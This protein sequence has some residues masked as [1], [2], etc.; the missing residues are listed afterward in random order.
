MQR[1]VKKLDY[2]LILSLKANIIYLH[3]AS[4]FI[5]QK[6]SYSTY[7]SSEETLMVIEGIT[8]MNLNLETTKK[9]S[10]ISQKKQN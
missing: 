4:L 6:K 5:I 9:K 8:L 3:Q 2:V 1:S 7:K 10:T